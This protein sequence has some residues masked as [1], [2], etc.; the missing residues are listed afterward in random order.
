MC[1]VLFLSSLLSVYNQ[2]YTSIT[3]LVGRH[4]DLFNPENS[5]RLREKAE[6]AF[7]IEETCI[8]SKFFILW[9]FILCE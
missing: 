2:L 4:E 3:Q 9:P 8:E 5:C 1:W 6:G 7:I